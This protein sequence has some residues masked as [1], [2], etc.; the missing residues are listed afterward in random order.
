[1]SH[2]LTADLGLCDLNA[3]LLAYDALVANPLI[4]SAVAFP[5]LCGTEYAFAEEAVLLG[6]ERSVV[7][8]LGFLHLAV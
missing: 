4:S 7:D 2:P 1:M 8:R 5:V 3:A 6:L